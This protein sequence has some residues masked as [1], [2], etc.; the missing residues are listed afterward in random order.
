EKIPPAGR[1]AR[2]VGSMIPATRAPVATRARVVPRRASLARR[3]RVS[4]R[5]WG[6]TRSGLLADVGGHE[7]SDLLERLVLLP[8]RLVQVDEL[9]PDGPLDG[10]TLGVGE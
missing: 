2:Q 5:R 6:S 8:G 10:G 3:G 1:E 7:R 4:S 9:K